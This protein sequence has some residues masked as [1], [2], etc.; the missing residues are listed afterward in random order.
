MRSGIRE[1]PAMNGASARTSPM[2]RP[3][4]I[5]SPPRFSKKR[6]TWCSRSSVI[7][8]RSPWRSSQARPSRRPIV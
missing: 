4:R 7:F 5:V 3:I 6:S 1:V 8:S 2:K